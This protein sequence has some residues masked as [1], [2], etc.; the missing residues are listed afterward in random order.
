MLVKFYT[1]AIYLII[2]YFTFIF[3]LFVFV[4]EPVNIALYRLVPVHIMFSTGF[5]PNNNKKHVV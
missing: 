5:C 3:S 2:L 1:I 4:G